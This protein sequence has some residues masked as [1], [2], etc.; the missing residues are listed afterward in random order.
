MNDEEYQLAVQKMHGLEVA[1]ESA[2]EQARMIRAK[3]EGHVTQKMVLGAHG[4][5]HA[6]IMARVAEAIQAVAPDVEAAFDHI[7]VQGIGGVTKGFV[8]RPASGT[9]PIKGRR[10]ATCSTPGCNVKHWGKRGTPCEQC[11][12]APTLEAGCLDVVQPCTEVAQ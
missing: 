10:R 3:F 11:L 9:D 2:L 5:S 4:A 1:L 8:D 12:A 7:E 6:T